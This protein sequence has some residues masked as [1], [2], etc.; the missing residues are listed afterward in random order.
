[1]RGEGQKNVCFCPRRGVKKQQNSV[2]VV[3]KCPLISFSISQKM[4]QISDTF[5]CKWSQSEKNSEIKPPL[6]VSI[7]VVED[8]LQK[9]LS[10][11][12]SSMHQL[13]PTALSAFGGKR[14]M[15]TC[16]L[17]TLLLVQ[18][19]KIYQGRLACAV[20]QSY[21]LW[22]KGVKFLQTVHNQNSVFF[23]LQ[24]FCLKLFQVIFS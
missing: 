5:F 2:H 13:Q 4:C 21:C 10:I 24:K 14:V 7:G 18:I 11:V 9:W 22:L 17:S 16:E 23:V 15:V 6:L 12:Q 8:G 3:V 19:I 1:M 20:Y